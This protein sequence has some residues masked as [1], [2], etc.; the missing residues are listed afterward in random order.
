MSVTKIKDTYQP[1]EGTLADKVIGWLEVNGGSITTGQITRIF[2]STNATVHRCL[3]RSVE[4]GL[5]R[6]FNVS[7]KRH[8]KLP[9]D[10]AT[11]VTQ[12]VDRPVDRSNTEAAPDAREFIV[13]QRAN[14]DFGILGMQITAEGVSVLTAKQAAMLC[15]FISGAGVSP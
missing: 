3:V 14:G 6:A 12:D 1:R 2:K 11:G 5:L 13:A 8:Y 7:H 4:A 15:G 9:T 10:A